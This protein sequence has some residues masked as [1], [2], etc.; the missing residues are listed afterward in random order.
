[1]E[2]EESPGLD[3]AVVA[4]REFEEVVVKGREAVVEEVVEVELSPRGPVPELKVGAV[5]D[6][7]LEEALPPPKGDPLKILLNQWLK[8]FGAR[9]LHMPA[10]YAAV[11]AV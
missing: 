8:I 1:V 4:G 3:K 7:S 6:R 2:D 5:P 11:G 10:G 9:N